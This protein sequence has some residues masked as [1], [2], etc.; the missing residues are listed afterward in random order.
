[1][2]KVYMKTIV[3][4][5]ILG[6][7]FTFVSFSIRAQGCSDTG[8]CTVS[9]FKPNGIETEKTLKNQFKI[10]MNYGAADNSIFVLG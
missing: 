7:C 9:S 3:I 4:K 10:G 2:I 1:M 8:F 6:L 5:V